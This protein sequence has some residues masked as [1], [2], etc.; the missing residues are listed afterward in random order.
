[1]SAY[2]TIQV[3][4]DSGANG[5]IA[6]VTVNR[7]EK[8]N[9]LN[10]AVIS[11]LTRAVEELDADRSVRVAIVTGAGPKAFVAGADIAAMA[12]M[13]VAEAKRFSEAGQRLASMIEAAHFVAIGAI[14]G[15]A[16]G[17]GCELALACDFLLAS[18]SAKFGQPEVNLGVIP[19]FGGT[20]RLMRRVGIGRARELCYTGDLISAGE[21]LRIG[22]VNAVVPP[23]ELM[24]RAREIAAK[25]AGKGPLAIE[26][27]KQVILRGEGMPLDAANELES[28]AFS[29]LFST[30]DQQEGMRAF[31]EKRAPNFAGK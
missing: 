23:G 14:N 6:V 22:L 16:L 15:F 17:G 20:Q 24:P 11:E 9:A 12:A 18:E 19:G 21:A 26:Q 29:A 31:I 3:E 7:P 8:M 13:S 25:I 2:E 1:M 30:D 28:K 4:R 5:A 10:A 27:C